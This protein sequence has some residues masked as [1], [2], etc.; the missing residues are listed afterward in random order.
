MD[1]AD[2]IRIAGLGKV[3]R[4]DGRETVELADVSLDIGRGNSSPLSAHL[5]TE[6]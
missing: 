6:R 1:A 4:R 2:G 5:N 3:F